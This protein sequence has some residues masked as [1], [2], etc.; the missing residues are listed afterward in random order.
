MPLL[1]ANL[2]TTAIVAIIL[3]FSSASI[4]AQAPFTVRGTVT[5]DKGAPLAGASVRLKNGTI[6]TSSDPSGVLKVPS[7]NATLMFSS[8]RYAPRELAL[9]NRSNLTVRLAAT[10]NLQNEVVVIGYGTQR[11][12]DITGLVTSLTAKDIQAAHPLMLHNLQHERHF[13]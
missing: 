3:L 9:K 8:V 10:E 13:Y 1:L 6:G 7:G 5:D 4:F 11:K 2:K 12:R